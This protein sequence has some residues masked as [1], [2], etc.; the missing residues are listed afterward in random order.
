MTVC[1]SAH[2]EK[3]ANYQEEGNIFQKYIYY[4]Q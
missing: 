1:T 3:V 2:M 4:D